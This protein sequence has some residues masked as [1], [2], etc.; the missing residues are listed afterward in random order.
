MSVS[1]ANVCITAA[2]LGKFTFI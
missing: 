2:I 1:I